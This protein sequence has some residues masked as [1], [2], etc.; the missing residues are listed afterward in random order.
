MADELERAFRDASSDDNVRP[1]IVTGAG[2]AFCAGVDLSVKG[3]V[4]GLDERLRPT[5]DDMRQM[6]PPLSIFPSDSI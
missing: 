2:R 1:I 3:N 4:F 5:I 6:S